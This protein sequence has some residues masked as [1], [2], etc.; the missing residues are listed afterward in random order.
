MVESVSLVYL[1]RLLIMHVKE[2]YKSR[3]KGYIG[4]T[5]IVAYI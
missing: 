1:S 3:L 5:K 2:I 4:I